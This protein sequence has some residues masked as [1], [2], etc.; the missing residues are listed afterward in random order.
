[1]TRVTSGTSEC[2]YDG[3]GNR[4]QTTGNG[5]DHLLP[6]LPLSDTGGR[7]GWVGGNRQRQVTPDSGTT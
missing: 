4:N 7:S 1:M 6:T 3:R 2:R 5:I